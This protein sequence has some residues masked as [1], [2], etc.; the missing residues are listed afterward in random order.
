[1]EQRKGDHREQSIIGAP[2]HDDDGWADI[3]L[4][5]LLV[6]HLNPFL[7]SCVTSQILGAAALSRPKPEKAA[8]PTNALRNNAPH[9]IPLPIL[10]NNE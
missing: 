7:A 8:S 10:V 3:D 4:Y 9:R 6:P 1:M 5:T 2:A